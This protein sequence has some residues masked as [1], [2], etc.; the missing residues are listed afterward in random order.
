M[1]EAS[2]GASACGA[3]VEASVHMCCRRQSLGARVRNGR[4]SLIARV[5]QAL[6]PRCACGAGVGDSVRVQHLRRRLSAR[7]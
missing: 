2:L 1:C 7:A 6:D 5:A 4:L 3:D